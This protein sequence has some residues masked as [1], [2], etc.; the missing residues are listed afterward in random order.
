ME[1]INMSYEQKTWVD[2]VSD[3]PTRRLLTDAGTSE[4]V[5]YD[6]TRAEGAVFNAGLQFNAETMNELEERIAAAFTDAETEKA[7]ILDTFY[8][9]GAVYISVV[10]TSPATLFG[11]T[12]TSITGGVLLTANSSGTTGGSDTI[13]YTPSGSIAFAGTIASAV[14]DLPSH[15]HSAN[16]PRISTSSS[17][18]KGGSDESF[19]NVTTTTS[20][21]GGGAGHTHGFTG[22]GTFTGTS[23]TYD[24]RMPY[25]TVYA[26]RRTA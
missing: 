25:I 3:Y 23:L 5:T 10:N 26:W 18:W 15:T 13:S 2:R 21:K 9:V 7:S 16:V 22:S 8:P 17:D 24:N 4:A 14:A 6:V 20:Y 11:G 1:E 19:N 12:W